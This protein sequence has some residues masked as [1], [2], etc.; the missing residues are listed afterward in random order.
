MRK[1]TKIAAIVSVAG[2]L[3]LGGCSW[4]SF[5]KNVWRGFGYSVG[6]LPASFVNGLIGDLLGNLGIN[7][8]TAN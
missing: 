1:I 5:T 2:M 7:L 8:G 4:D 6:G 3:Q